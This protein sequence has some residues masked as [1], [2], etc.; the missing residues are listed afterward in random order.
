MGVRSSR[1]LAA[2]SLQFHTLRGSMAVEVVVR[3]ESWEHFK[4]M[5]RRGY[6]EQWMGYEGVESTFGTFPI[7]RGQSSPRWTLMS[8][9]ERTLARIP[10]R[11]A[12]AERRTNWQAMLEKIRHDF[13]ELATGLPGLHGKDLD[14][15]D[16]WAIGR[17]Y[18]LVTPLLDWTRSP[19][20]AAFF[21]FMD[22]AESVSPRIKIGDIDTPAFLHSRPDVS[23]AIWALKVCPE[24]AK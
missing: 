2:C 14:E 4:D 5:V 7:F 23:V 12:I 21:A 22:Y 18:G 3:C 15:H 8:Q 11:G 1:S 16:W 9:W 6:A 19:Y 24:L 13:M 17:H 20:V 10:A